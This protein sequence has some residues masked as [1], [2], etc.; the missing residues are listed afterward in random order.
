MGPRPKQ[1]MW[2]RDRKREGT[3]GG[4]NG[5]EAGVGELWGPRAGWQ[6]GWT[7]RAT[8]EPGKT[9]TPMA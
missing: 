2:L 3:P 4:W 5:V 8:L 6:A 9:H 7:S 1:E